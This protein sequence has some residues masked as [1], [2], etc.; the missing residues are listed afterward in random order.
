MSYSVLIVDDS[1][2]F[3]RHLTDIINA[4]PEFR[5]I[6]CAENGI[7]AVEMAAS[8]K[9]DVITMDYEMPG[10][11]GLSAVRHIM[12]DNPTPI[13]MLSS[14]TYEGARVTFDA[15]EAG[16]LDFL[17]K[18]FDQIAV[19]D[20]RI[21]SEIHERL[22]S[23]VG[24]MARKPLAASAAV[25]GAAAS[26]SAVAAETAQPAAVQ[27][28]KSVVPP[29]ATKSSTRVVPVACRLLVL[30]ASTGGPMAIGQI[31]RNLPASF[32]VPIVIVQHMPPL[33]TREFSERLDRLSALQVKEAEEGDLLKAGCVLVAPGGKQLLF[34][35]KGNGAI[36]LREERDERI[37]YQPSVDITLGSAASC[38]G[39]G[40]LAVVMTGMGEDG[41]RGAK[42]VKDHGGNVWIQDE[43]SCVVYGMPGAIARKGLSDKT[44]KLDDL[45]SELSRLR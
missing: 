32:S 26:V 6:G 5:V 22:L 7:Q 11:D 43:S 44:V 30:G 37:L 14:L 27:P 2:F 33:F 29:A 42:I 17:P 12:R 8:L 31:L 19:H 38:F 9:P 1:R 41:C 39:N 21:K 10:M 3:R 36:T 4:N 24:K 45:G 35:A 23:V 20:N 34:D 18:K 25:S 15:L 40:V 16:A 28:A 13:L